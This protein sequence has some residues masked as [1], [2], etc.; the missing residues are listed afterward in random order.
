MSFFLEGLRQAW[1]EITTPGSGI[2]QVVRVT[3]Q[4]AGVSTLAGLV[5]GLPIGVALGIGRF[6]GRGAL[7]VLA[8]A[9][10]GLPP[11]LVGVVLTLLF[12]PEAP[13]GFLR[14]GFSLKGVYV[15]QTV[16]AVPVVV[17][18]TASAIRDLP[19]G[20]LDQGRAFGASR[21]ALG[22]LAVREAR[23]GILAAT[24]AAI[25]GGLSEVGAVVLVGGNVVGYDQTL[26]SAALQRVGAGDYAGA[27]A[28]GILLLALILL[29]VAALTW[30][31]YAGRRGPRA[32][33]RA[34]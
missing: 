17:A 26:A 20:L 14:L 8:N 10:L 5:I 12:F 29:V 9:G 24:I 23:I 11:V 13:L 7:L 32:T 18:L 4:V 30:L 15:A 6:R 3:L 31:Q 22:V 19:V 16:L 1:Q 21:L 25:G 2:W 34:S 28:V 33:V 27:M